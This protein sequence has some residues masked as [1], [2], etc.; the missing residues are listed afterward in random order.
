MIQEFLQYQRA[1]KGLS[2]QTLEG[3]MKDLK[4]FVRFSQSHGLRWSTIT[5]KD[6]DEYVSEEHER[7]MQPRTIKKRVEV[8][9]LLFSW[10]QHRGLLADNPARYTQTPKQAEELPK[11]A[12]TDRLRKYLERDAT[13]RESYIIHII[14]A[15]I[16]ETGMRIGEITSMRGEDID[17]KNHA[18]LVHGKGAKERYVYYGKLCERYAEAMSHRA[19]RI[20]TQAQTDYRYMMYAELPGTHPHA[21]RHAFAIEQ[22]NRGLELKTLSTL[23]GHKHTTTTEIYTHMLTDNVRKQYQSIN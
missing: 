22:L 6:L 18:I 7:G 23:M 10:A 8:V 14:V 1:N 16:L 20:F 19:G 9:R 17:T 3:Y 5:P 21:I 11:A 15:L 4:V 13:S 2:E 12:D